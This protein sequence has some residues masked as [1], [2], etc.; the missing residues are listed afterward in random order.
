LEL[1]AKL[2][3][4]RTWSG[5]VAGKNMIV[6][7]LSINLANAPAYA[8][9]CISKNGVSCPIIIQQITIQAENFLNMFG[10]M[11][12]NTSDV[13]GGRNV[14]DILTGDWMSYLAAT[15]P[16]TGVYRVEY[17][18]ASLSSGGS[19]QFEKAGGTPEYGGISIPV[20][21]GYQTWTMISHTVNQKCW[22]PILWHQSLGWWL[23]PQMVPYNQGLE[24]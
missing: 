2:V 19:L 9:V 1:V 21:G 14:G 18:V 22:L 23:E 11:T 12:K 3:A 13:G 16:I 8:R 15:I 10:V 5:A 20:T 17:H 4:G 24:S 6:S 7:M